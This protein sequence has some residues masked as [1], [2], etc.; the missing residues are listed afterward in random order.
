MKEHNISTEIIYR[1]GL[2]YIYTFAGEERGSSWVVTQSSLGRSG[3]ISTI[4]ASWIPSLRSS[5]PS[6]CLLACVRLIYLAAEATAAVRL[7]PAFK[8]NCFR[9]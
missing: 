9:C 7:G 2:Y 3:V 5:L 1:K 8:V 6:L 4:L